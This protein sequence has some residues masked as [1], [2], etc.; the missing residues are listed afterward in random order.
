MFAS[1]F[2]IIL[3]E[4]LLALGL[5]IFIVWYTIPKKKKPPKE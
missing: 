2:W 5:A 4:M 3:L 1:G